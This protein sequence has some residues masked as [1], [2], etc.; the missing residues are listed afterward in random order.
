MRTAR[1]R[2]PAGEIAEVLVIAVLLALFVRTHFVQA[3]RIPTTS[4]GPGLSAGDHV[5]VNKLIYGGSPGWLGPVLPMRPVR[6]GDV[7]V[8]RS[9]ENAEDLVKRCVAVGGDT[10]A[11]RDK[12]LL[13]NG[14]P[15]AEPYVQHVDSRVY[16][17]AVFLDRFFRRRDNLAPQWIPPDQLFVLGDNRDL[18]RDSRVFGPVPASRLRGRALVIYLSLGESPGGSWGVLGR[19][20]WDRSLRVV[21]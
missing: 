7:V 15:V 4:M 20:R 2:S 10:V 11:L 18:S 16:P 17:D 19:I 14:K 9:I 13:V 5:L 12:Q 8:F 21:R 1:R 3:F 6:R